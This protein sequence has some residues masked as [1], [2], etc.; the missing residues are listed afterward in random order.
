MKFREIIKE[1]IRDYAMGEYMNGKKPTLFGFI[2]WG[3]IEPII[4]RIQFSICERR[5]HKYDNTGGYANGDTG[6]DYFTC[7]R[8][9]HEFTHIYY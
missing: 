5:G 7:S 8:C 4:T 6:G 1:E 9:G 3:Y 2:R